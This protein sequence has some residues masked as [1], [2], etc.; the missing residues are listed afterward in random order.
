MSDG[1][2]DMLREIIASSQPRG[3]N[4]ADTRHRIIDFVL[5]HLFAWPHIAV[6][7]EEY[8]APGY[9][10]YV[11]KR[12]SNDPA[13][14]VEAKKSGVYFELPNAVNSSETHCYIAIEKLLSDNN[15][16][17]AMSQVRTYC[18]DT[19]CEFACIT[20]G[21]EWIFFK[22][23]ERGKRWESLRAFVVRRIEFFLEDYIKA[24]NAFSYSSITE[25][26]SLT[27]LLTSSPPKDRT[28][29]Y[30]KDRIPSYSHTITSN[31]LAATLRPIVN[32]YFGVIGDDDT[33][34]ME[35]C[36]VSQRDYQQTFDGVRGLIEDSLSPYFKNYGVNQLVETGKGGQLGGRLTKN[37]KRG[38]KG[39]VLILFGGKGAG[40]STFI[41]RLLH[42]NPPRWL[43]DHSVV[44][45]VDLLKVPED[46]ELI[47]RAIWDGLVSS[48]DEEGLLGADRAVLLNKLFLDRYETAC[49]QELSG[50]QR[51]SEIFNTRLNDL[52]AVWK[53]DKRYCANRLVDYWKSQDKGVIVVV[54]NTD[55]YSAL[56]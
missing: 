40:K 43:R 1:V 3:E 41:K 56:N 2:L 21:H 37:I 28:I 12:P 33:D 29:Y 7:A 25:Q 50:L 19:G 26:M 4:E 36:Y 48:L 46:R 51:S 20:N 53:S 8:I 14:F 45:I 24:Y 49:R 34:F 9:A 23:F 27:S 54:D 31:R 35:R 18:L 47:R 52:V 13:I 16:R 5:Y 30:A 6:S 55:Q 44:A 42:H 22:I 38:R 32:H 17:A 10:D 11:L 39:E 15:I